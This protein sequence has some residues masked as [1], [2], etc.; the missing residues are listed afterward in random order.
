MAKQQ[1]N[2]IPRED[3]PPPYTFTD[4][5]TKN[6]MD[7][8]IN[9]IDDVITDEDIARVKVPGTETPVTPPQKEEENK[10]DTPPGNAEG[11]PVTPWDV[12]D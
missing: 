10:N 9:D 8:H 5:V 12:I 7:K 1:K 3:K 6:K 11:K 2:E 4:E